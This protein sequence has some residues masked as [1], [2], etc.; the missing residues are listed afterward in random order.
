[1]FFRRIKKQRKDQG[2]GLVFRWRGARRHHAGK[3]LALFITSSLFAFAA[4]ALR[5]EGMRAPLLTKRTGE[6]VMLN[7]D[8]PHCQDLMLQ[9]EDQSPFLF[10]WDPAYDGLSMGRITAAVDHL[11]GGVWGYQPAM[12]S[13]PAGVILKPLPSIVGEGRRVFPSAVSVS[14]NDGGVAGV[15]DGFGGDVQVVAKISGS[16]ELLARLHTRSLPLAEGLIA[17]EWYGQSFR[18]LCGIDS[19]GVVRGCLPLSG[20][21]MEVAKPTQKLLAAWLRRTSFKVSDDDRPVIGILELQIEAREY[22]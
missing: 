4:Y 1:M 6:V 8:D 17:D 16:K 11:S 14:V 7:E 12:V 21:N 18:F 20:G 9:V 19:S 10:R 15:D 13:L 22:D 2:A 3:F 5:V